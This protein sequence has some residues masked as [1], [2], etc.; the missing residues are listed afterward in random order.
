MKGLKTQL[1]FFSHAVSFMFYWVNKTSFLEWEEI[2][3]LFEKTRFF[4][5]VE[6]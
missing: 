2:S 4:S 5:T 6:L 3:V 1:P